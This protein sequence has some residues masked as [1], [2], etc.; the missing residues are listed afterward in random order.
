MRSLRNPFFILLLAGNGIFAQTECVNYYDN[1]GI[2]NVW[3]AQTW[4]A[5][6]WN[7]TDMKQKKVTG[8]NI[9]NTYYFKGLLEY[10][11]ESYIEPANS[12]KK[13]PVII[14]FHGGASNGEG[15]VEHLCRL[16][17]DRGSDMATHKSLPGRIEGKNG[18]TAD[19]VQGNDEYVVISPQFTV[20][21]RPLPE[22]PT[23]HHFPSA[24]EV[25]DV[26]DYVVANYRVD[27]NRIYLT[28]Y[29]NGA[30]MIVEYAASSVAR[31]K[32]VAA[33]MPI[34]FCSTIS[35]PR[36]TERNYIPENIGAAGLPTWFVH[37]N[38]DNPC[39]LTTPQEWITA[40]KNTPGNVTPRFT[41]LNNANPN[42]L[43]QC[44]DTLTH[45]AWSRA[46]D[47]NFR[48][49]FIN[50][51]GSDDGINMNMYE[52]FL[53]QTI[54]LPVS[55]K[56]FTARLVKD[57][58]ELKWITTDEKTTLPLLLKELALTSISLLLPKFQAL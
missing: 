24:D 42:P 16:F 21:S 28:G 7:F 53:Q 54:A 12:A 5:A 45:D 46:Y 25:E 33:I 58:V 18:I 39:A 41:V 43:Y 14:Y 19:L 56:I 9:G 32:R 35:S 50:G 2:G 52:W 48:T 13:Y 6:A 1:F 44:S 49:S 4:N 57:N 34:S 51:T 15:T 37:C 31:A 30:N 8:L 47:P 10:T 55:L 22:L 20:Y 29:S 11:P 40:I 38:I 17:K 23:N 26:I 27:E 36:N 3:D